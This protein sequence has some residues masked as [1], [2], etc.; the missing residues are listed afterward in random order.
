MAVVYAVQMWRP[1]L[2]G[3]HFVIMT[4]HR[5]IQYFLIQRITTPMQQ[6]WLAKLVGYDYVVQFRSGAH[7]TVADALSRVGELTTIQAI[8]SPVMSYLEE[9]ASR[10]E[11]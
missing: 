7:N 2:L 8:S 11:C 3:H 9:N 5:T 10:L 1:Y 4:D 6:K